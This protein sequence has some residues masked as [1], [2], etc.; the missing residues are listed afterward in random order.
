MV[1]VWTNHRGVD[2]KIAAIGIRVKKWI[3]FHG[4]AINVNPNLEHFSGIIPCGIQEFGITSLHKLGF[5]ISLETL[6]SILISKF[7]DIFL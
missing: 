4:I 7:H 3:C 1:G 5:S 6:D 2:E